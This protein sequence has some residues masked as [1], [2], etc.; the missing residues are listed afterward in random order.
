ME[1]T[2]KELYSGSIIHSRDHRVVQAEAM[3]IQSRD[4]GKGAEKLKKYFDNPDCVNKTWPKFW[5]FME[6]CKNIK[7]K[8]KKS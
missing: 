6:Y 8:H 4:K 7:N 2:L 5:D 3:L 1:R